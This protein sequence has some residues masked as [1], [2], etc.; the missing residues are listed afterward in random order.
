M[1]TINS[2]TFQ[3]D[4]HIVN[5]SRIACRDVIF[6][7]LTVGAKREI[8]PHFSQESTFFSAVGGFYE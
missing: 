2:R 8:P 7:A 3:L 6:L 4:W 5:P 1:F